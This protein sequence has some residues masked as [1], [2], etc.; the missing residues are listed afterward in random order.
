MFIS[1]FTCFTKP[2]TKLPSGVGLPGNAQDTQLNLNFR[3]NNENF[4]S[5]EVYA[6]Y[7]IAHIYTIEISVASL[8]SNLTGY[9]AFYLAT[10]KEQPKKIGIRLN[11]YN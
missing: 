5:I 2:V 11:S 4:L 8:N 6:K 9:S 3:K 1:G 10:L 7:C